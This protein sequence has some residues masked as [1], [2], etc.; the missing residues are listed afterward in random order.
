LVGWDLMVAS[1]VGLDGTGGYLPPFDFGDA[2][3]ERPEEMGD[4]LGTGECGR[5]SEAILVTA[6]GRIQLGPGGDL[7]LMTGHPVIALPLSLRQ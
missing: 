2:L 3:G 1:P 7:V 6:D 5:L 4:L